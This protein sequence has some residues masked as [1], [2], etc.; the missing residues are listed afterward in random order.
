MIDAFGRRIVGWLV[1]RTAHASFVLDALEQALHDSPPLMSA[2]SCTTATRA[3]NSIHS[4]FRMAGRSRHKTIRRK[5]G[6]QLPQRSHRND[7]RSLQGRSHSST[8]AVSQFRG[9]QIRDP[10]VGQFVQPSAASGAHRQHAASRSR[11]AVLRQAGRTGH[12]CRTGTKWPLANPQQFKA[13]RFSWFK[14]LERIRTADR[15]PDQLY[16]LQFSLGVADLRP[17]EAV[18]MR[19][20]RHSKKSGNRDVMKIESIQSLG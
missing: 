17:P 12:S 5:R 6:R 3:P 19:M 1:S 2:V 4:L 14:R 13:A 18:E 15:R 7:Q 16:L 9:G 11:G 10:E 20:D 8:W